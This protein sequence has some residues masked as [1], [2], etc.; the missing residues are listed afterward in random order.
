[1]SNHSR[2][3]GK[4]PSASPLSYFK[5]YDSM[6]LLPTPAA[7]G[8]NEETTSST[9]NTRT[10]SIITS[11]NASSCRSVSFGSVKITSFPIV[12]SDNPGGKLGGPPIG[13]APKPISAPSATCTFDL[14]VYEAGRAGKRRKPGTMLA[15]PSMR[16]DW[17]KE[18]GYTTDQIRERI[19]E[20]NSIKKQ[21]EI[22]RRSKGPI[23]LYDLR[24]LVGRPF[25]KVKITS[26]C[27]RGSI[28]AVKE[29][30]DDH[31]VVDPLDSSLL[32]LQ[33]RNYSL[34]APRPVRAP[35][36]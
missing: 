18:A 32:D 33:S 34:S 22:S 6:T 21:R 29:Q 15:S 14:D 9:C 31:S 7:K 5:H 19:N 25:A 11:S 16:Y 36:A 2:S 24:H 13:L 4:M 10:K 27:C 35:S 26:C 1:M 12:L 8:D 3:V 20:T 17:A 23:L 28:H 30:D